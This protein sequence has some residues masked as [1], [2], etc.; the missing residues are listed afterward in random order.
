MALSNTAVPKYYGAF[1]D[2]V[3]RGEITVNNEIFNNGKNIRKGANY[4]NNYAKYLAIKGGQAYWKW[5]RS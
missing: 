3:I 4:V 1:R 2:A 5:K